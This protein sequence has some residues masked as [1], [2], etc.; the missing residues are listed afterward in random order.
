MLQIEPFVYKH[1]DYV[2]SGK[3]DYAV[4]CPFCLERY[5]KDDTKHKLQISMVKQTCHCWRCEYSASW[6]QLVQDVTGLSYI[7]AMAELYVV[8]KPDL[9]RL[10]SA[11]NSSS[12][13]PNPSSTVFIMPE[14]YKPLSSLPYHDSA[15]SRAVKRYLTKRGFGKEYWKKYH[16]GYVPGSFR[17][18][19]PIEGSFWQARSISSLIEPKYMSPEV[20]AE[21]VLFN[22]Q[23]LEMYD[24]VVVTEGFFSA[25][26]VGDNTV[27]LV[28]K[29][30]TPPKVRR[31]AESNVKRFIIAVEERAWSILSLA[32]S[33]VARGKEVELWVYDGDTDPADRVKP[34]KKHYD[35]RAR[36]E[37]EFAKP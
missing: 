35:L 2:I 21:D 23:A 30:P 13:A 9:S 29:N 33:L 7:H 26:A 24:E 17:V 12:K 27:A 20:P 4:D 11:F 19:F 25:I 36:L 6:V 16:I 28:G 14:G 1:F 8:P 32:D 37:M 5:G 15:E 22:A 31:L 3:Q 10:H 18:Y 34:T